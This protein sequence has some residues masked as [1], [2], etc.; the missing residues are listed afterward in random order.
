MDEEHLS[1]ATMELNL[2][3]VENKDFKNSG[4]YRLTCLCQWWL[5]RTRI[6]IEA[7]EAGSLVYYV[8]DYAVPQDG[9]HIHDA[10]WDGDLVI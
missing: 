8:N 9:S 10:Q 7:H 2:L 3:M 6:H 1:Q 5:T 4:Q